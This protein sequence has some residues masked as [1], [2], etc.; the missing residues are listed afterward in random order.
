MPVLSFPSFRAYLQDLMFLDP[1][2]STPVMLR[3][4]RF[5]V[6]NMKSDLEPQPLLRF[7]A[8]HYHLPVVELWASYSDAFSVCFL[9]CEMGTI[10]ASNRDDNHAKHI[11][12]MSRSLEL[13][14]WL[15][16]DA[17]VLPYCDTWSWDIYSQKVIFLPCH[18]FFWVSIYVS[19]FLLWLSVSVWKH[20][21]SDNRPAP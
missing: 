10:I 14:C 19:H 17:P 16:S 15:L 21:T 13:L 4:T 6:Q 1:D 2:F 11:R 8:W 12:G 18:I 20:L 9:T 5:L 7:S 3:N